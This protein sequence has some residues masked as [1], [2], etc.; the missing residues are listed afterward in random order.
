MVM[1]LVLSACG[2]AAEPTATAPAATAPTAAPAG[3]EPAAPA[4]PGAPVPDAA[5]TKVPA[6]ATP[7]AAA[8]GH[9]YTD[10]EIK[11]MKWPPYTFELT[12]KYLSEGFYLPETRFG[13]KE[14]PKYGGVAIFAHRRDI[15]S[16]DPMKTATIS[17]TGLT[18]QIHSVGNLV[19]SKRDV[20]AEV[21][22]HIAETWEVS[23]D[24][25]A[26]T[27]NLR[28]DIQWH[29]GTPL[30]AED[31]KFWMDLA[32]FP[33]EGRFLSTAA[34]Y[35]GD[36]K[37]VQVVDDHTVRLVMNTPAPWLLD[38]LQKA[39]FSHPRHLAQPL[40]EGGNP[41][42]QMADFG[43]VGM[44]PYKFD[45]Y[46]PGSRFRTVRNP[47]YYE[48]DSEGRSLPYMDGIDNPIIQDRTVGISAFRAGRIDGTARGSGFFL[49][50]SDVVNVNKDLPGKA[51]FQ[52]TY[53]SGWG[54]VLNATTAPFDDINLRKAVQL[55][56]DR[57][58]WGLSAYGGFA[59][60]NGI[61][62]PGSYWYNP[63]A[64]TY[65]GFDMSK[66]EED[67]A[68]AKRLVEASGYDGMKVGQNCRENYL[69]NCESFDIQARGLGLA[70]NINIL[71][72]NQN[73]ERQQRGQYQ[74][75]MSGGGVSFP[76]Q[77]LGNWKTSN[78]IHA[79]KSGDPKFDEY[80]F[81]IQT[82]LDPLKRRD[83]AWEVEHYILVEKAYQIPGP[84]EEAVTAYRAHIKNM[85]I[86]WDSPLQ[87]NEHATVWY[88]PAM[89]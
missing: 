31:V 53:Y 78:P 86:S 24:F 62:R 46:D 40:I 56:I 57:V 26:W 69:F 45:R 51:W 73:T 20:Q 21:E 80:D 2:Q 79:Y 50:P 85:P 25:K 42:V 60:I 39:Y 67:R 54:P 4:E 33:P 11:A 58:E 43:W 59:Q 49:Q 77:M 36:L 28:K 87:N 14:E 27:F 44:G 71:D 9:P 41:G 47:N 88:D 30:V 8:S 63:A 84:W 48:K 16:S 1:I 70:M 72:T 15:P 52:R 64:A 65:P 7:A 17:L 34:R 13:A 35:F 66:K 3:A 55:W 75:L 89:K 81:I 6:A 22:G 74:S 76:G 37:E 10:A 68:E 82:T 29:D 32:K 61:L 23:D 18:K 12:K 38:T 83:T 5:A 19:R